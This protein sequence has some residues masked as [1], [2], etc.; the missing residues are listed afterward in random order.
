MRLLLILLVLLSSAATAEVYKSVGSDGRAIYTDRPIENATK[1]DLSSPPET[2]PVPSPE[3]SAR[4]GEQ[5]FVGPYTSFEIASPQDNTTLRNEAREIDVSILLDPPL[6][7]DHRLRVEVDG[8]D[9]EGDLG[10][11][12]QIRLSGLS[13]GSHRV[14]AR[15]EDDADGVV[16]ATPLINV[17]VRQPLPEAVLP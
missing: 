9:A 14:Q 16:A 17:H 11:R 2:P 7:D 15:I 3:P 8:V 13:F 4:A 5:G 6:Q 12:T 10:K 1:L